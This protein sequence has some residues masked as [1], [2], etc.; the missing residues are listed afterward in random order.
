MKPHQGEAAEELCKDN[1]HRKVSGVLFMPTELTSEKDR[2]NQ[3]IV[4]ALDRTNIPLVLLDCC[5]VP[6]SIW[7]RS[8][9][10]LQ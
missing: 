2:A 3:W 10:A 5:H 9:R 8:S 4:C 1:I 6:F 7:F